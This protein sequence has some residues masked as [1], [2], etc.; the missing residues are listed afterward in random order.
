[1]A[2][3]WPIT[4]PGSP[5]KLKPD[6]SNGH[7]GPS[8][9][10]CRPTW[11]QMPGMVAPR[12][13]SLASSGLPV[14]VCAPDTTHEFEPMPSPRPSSSGSAAAAFA[15]PSSD[16]PSDVSRGVFGEVFRDFSRAGSSAPR[17][18]SVRAAAVVNRPSTTAPD[19]TI[20]SLRSYGYG[21]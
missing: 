7:C 4:T 16:L 3:L 9:L 13:G 2:L 15:T 17:R 1:M 5:A 21:G 14:V 6:T 11:L 10:Q 20:G 12:C 18:T 19:R 8:W